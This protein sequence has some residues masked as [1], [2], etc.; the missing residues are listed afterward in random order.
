MKKQVLAFVC[1]AAIL[2]TGVSSLSEAKA[3]H[4]TVSKWNASWSYGS[5]IV[6]NGRRGYSNL[7][8]SLRYHSSSV[9]IGEGSDFSGTAKPGVESK[10]SRVAGYTASGHYYYNIW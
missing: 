4:E 3:A 7:G 5:S 10:S 1:A 2:G 9:T 8:S 6:I